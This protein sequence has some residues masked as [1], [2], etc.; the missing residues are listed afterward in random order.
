MIEFRNVS[1]T[2]GGR[3]VLDGLSFHVK[4]GET[5]IIV[6][7]SGT[8]KSVT[9]SHIIGLM[10]PD[11]GDVI[12]DGMHVERMHRREL[13]ALR[14]GTGMLFQG[15]ALLNWMNI[16]DNVALPLRERYSYTEEQIR[17]KVMEMLAFLEFEPDIEETLYRIVQESTTNAIRHG[18]ATEIWIRISEKNGE[19]ILMVSDNGRGCAD[20]EEGFGLKHMRERVEL[21]GGSLFY[22]GV[23]GFTVIVKIPIRRRPASPETT[24]RI[25][26]VFPTISP[27]LRL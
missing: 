21:A 18:K 12:V 5:F 25:S 19:M 16:Y 7:P 11:S 22:E 10:Q 23:F 14:S 26:P 3:R 1:K 13:E 17:E 15:G 8:G 9:L 4:E 27:P 20:I 6:G 24:A 2:L